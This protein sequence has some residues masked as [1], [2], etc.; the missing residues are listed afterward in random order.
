[1]TFRPGG[2]PGRP[3]DGFPGA[4]FITDHERRWDYDNGNQVAEVSI[5]VPVISKNPADLNYAGFIQG[6]HDVLR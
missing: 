6:F 2:D 4:L 5:P 1:M 3:S